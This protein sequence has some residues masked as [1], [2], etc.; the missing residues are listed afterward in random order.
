MQAD[1]AQ[2]MSD[3]QAMIELDEKIV[4]MWFL[5]LSEKSDWMLAVREITAEEKYEVVFRFRY[6]KDDKAFDS[7]DKK[8]WY[9]GTVSGTRAYVIASLRAAAQLIAT[10][11]I[12]PLYELLN[13][14]GIDQFMRELQD[15]P[16]AHVRIE[17]TP[18]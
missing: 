10:T 16:F 9:K 5:Y 7:D 17:D 18:R 13:E 15:A 14:R 1:G 8:N 6:Y 11:A 3:R 12:E 2:T 4:G